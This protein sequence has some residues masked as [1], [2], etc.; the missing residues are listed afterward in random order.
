MEIKVIKLNEA[1]T[2]LLEKFCNECGT[3]GFSN[4]SSLSAMKFN[5]KY[6][7]DEVPTFFATLIDG[8]I[9]SVSGSHSFNS[10]D[11]RVG[12]RAAALPRFRGIIKGLSKT[13]MTNLVWAPLMPEIILDG[14]EQGYENFYITTSHTTHDASG[15]MHRTHKALQLLAKQKIVDF[16][17]I[18]T[19]YH[20]PQTKW[21]FNLNR[22]FE[23]VKAF[24]PIR[25]ELNIM[26]YKY[27]LDNPIIEKYICY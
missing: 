3:L 2:E 5:G 13:H 10:N 23:T 22:F 14:L 1:H 26:S 12:F 16:V 25:Q 4:N 8:E 24:E 7:L 18:E 19:F 21:K 11:L 9:A 27:S 15:K 20:I 17:K 6:D